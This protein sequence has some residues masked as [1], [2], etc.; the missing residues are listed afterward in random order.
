MGAEETVEQGIAANKIMVFS[1]SYCPFCD[2]AKALLRRYGVRFEYYELDLRD[3]GADIQ[4]YLAQK[5]GQRTVP[6]IFING[7]QV[8]GCDDLHRLDATGELTNLLASKL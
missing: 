5:T 4:A 1:K 7:T 2:K 8:G 3:D 6:N